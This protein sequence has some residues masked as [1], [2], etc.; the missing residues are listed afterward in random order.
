MGFNY[1]RILTDILTSVEVRSLSLVKNAFGP[2]KVNIL[3]FSVQDNGILI[4]MKIQIFNHIIIVLV[5][6]FGMGGTK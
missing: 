3:Q 6:S 2:G 1:S 4:R 5:M